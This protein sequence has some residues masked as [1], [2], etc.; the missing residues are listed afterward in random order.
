MRVEYWWPSH[1][2]GRNKVLVPEGVQFAL[3]LLL[4][5]EDGGLLLRDALDLPAVHLVPE[6]RQKLVRFP[7]DARLG[8]GQ[9]RLPR[10]HRARPAHEVAGVAVVGGDAAVSIASWQNKNLT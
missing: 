2:F 9:R 8:G 1:V 3:L 7:G 5:V 4:L 6:A 10:R